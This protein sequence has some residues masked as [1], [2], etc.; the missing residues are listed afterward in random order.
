MKRML[1]TGTTQGIG[2]RIFDRFKDDYEIITINRRNFAHVGFKSKNYICD[3]SDIEAVKSV[4]AQIVDKKIDVLINNA[5][6]GEPIRFSDMQADDLVK[7]TNLNYHAPILLMQAVIGGMK[8]R[9]FGKIVNISSIASKAPRPFIPHYG[10]AKSALEK[11]SSSM[12][13]YYGESGI[14]INCI[15]PGGVKTDT[16]I[17]NRRQMAQL[18]GLEEDFYNKSMVDQNGLGRMIL[19]DEVVDL[20][21]FLLSD[22][23][24]AI[25]G[26]VINICGT[27]E[28]R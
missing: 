19:P 6:G 17:K 14:S 12:A 15:C 9:G 10:A 16:S 20:V 1:I 7:C 26:Q 8:E 2:Y 4:V 11:F 22:K 18:S 28:V 23:A 25:S 5:G 24:G 21:E 13:V 27:R 3:L